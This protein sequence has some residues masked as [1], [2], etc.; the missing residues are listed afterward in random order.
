MTVRVE[1]RVLWDDVFIGFGTKKSVYGCW[2]YA[3]MSE[4][5]MHPQDTG[6]ISINWVI[7]DFSDIFFLLI[8]PKHLILRT[9]E[10]K[11]DY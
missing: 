10:K 11:K 2:V 9:I 8:L 4:T 7:A 6:E 3:W 5:H 1:N